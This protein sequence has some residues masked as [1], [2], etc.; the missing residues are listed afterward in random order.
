M[1]DYWHYT[2]DDAYNAVVEEAMLFQTGP[3]QNSYM[4]PNV[5]VSLGNDDQAFWGMSALLA[6]E[7]NFHN[8]P[9]KEPQWLELAQAVFNT[10]AS[11]MRHDELCGGGLRWQIPPVNVGYDY[12]N[13]IAN[14]CFFNLGARLARYTTNETYAMW[15]EKTWD[16]MIGVG[17][18]DHDYNIYD[19]AHTGANCTD[20]NH[21]QYSYNVAIF[22]QGAA[23]MYNYVGHAR[24]SEPASQNSSTP[25]PLNPGLVR[26]AI[27]NSAPANTRPTAT[28][29]GRPAS[30]ACSAT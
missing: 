20:I 17:M 29:S 22:L 7:V 14:G 10:Q 23:F 11:P 19:G 28:P 9:S 8:P 1:I 3:P 2:G 16:W 18:I 30:R 24:C 13:A 12:K 25:G 4:P 5:T 26:S 27:T 15:A 21:A 6:A